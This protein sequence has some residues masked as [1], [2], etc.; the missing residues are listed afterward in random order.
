MGV[1]W[2]AQF[3]YKRPKREPEGLESERR[4]ATEAGDRNAGGLQSWEG[5][6]RDSP[7]DA[8][9]QPALLILTL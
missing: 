9:E 6:G 8:P 2:V 3:E 4:Q 7:L 5:E 1:I